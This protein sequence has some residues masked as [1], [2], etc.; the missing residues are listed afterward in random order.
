MENITLALRWARLRIT[1]SVT[2]D[3]TIRM[4]IRDGLGTGRRNVKETDGRARQEA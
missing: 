4:C 3:I 2:T 1:E